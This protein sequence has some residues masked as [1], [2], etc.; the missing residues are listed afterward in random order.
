MTMPTPLPSPSTAR[1][2]SRAVATAVDALESRTL[3]SVAPAAVDAATATRLIDNGFAA[4]SWQHRQ[5]FAAPNEWVVELDRGATFK[6]ANKLVKGGRA[7]LEVVEKLTA[8]GDRVLV[9]V[10][11]GAKAR[12]AYAALA[13]VDGVGRVEPN[14][15]VYAEAVAPN[16]T[17][18][19]PHQWGLNN[20]GQDGGKADADIDA[21]E[22]WDVTTGSSSVVVAVVDSG[23]QYT[24]PDLAANMWRNPGEVAGDNVDND[25]N[26]YRDDVHGWNFVSN[27]GNPMDDNGHGTH[28]AGIIA[29]AGNNAAGVTGTSWNS[30]VMALKFL[31]SAGTG[32][33]A[34]AIKALDYARLM[35][36]TYGVN[37]RVINNSWGGGGFSQT[38]QNAIA[39]TETGGMLFVAAAGNGGS[40]GVGD[41]NDAV[42]VYPPSSTSAN[43]VA[44]AATDRNDALGTFSNYGATSVDLAAP[45]VDV[46]STYTGS[47]YSYLS[48]TSMATPYVS[49]VAALAFGLRPASTYQQVKDALLNGV[50]KV[51]GLTGKVL[52]GGRLNARK[53][54]DLIAA[55]DAPAAPSGLAAAAQGD[56]TIKLTWTDGSNNEQGFRV[57]RSA[58]GGGFAE[59]GTVGAN[60]A[61]YF[62]TAA[63]A[64]VAYAYRVRA[65]NGTNNSAFSN[66]AS[67]TVPVPVVATTAASV[68][69]VDSATAG[70][71]KG[72]YG[73]EGYTVVGDATSAPAYGSV[74]AAGKF[75]WTWAGSTADPRALQKAGSATDRVAATWYHS[76]PFAVDINL[77][78]TVTHRVALYMLDY[79]RNGRSQRVDVLDPSSGQVLATQAVSDFGDGKYVVLD[80]RGSVRVRVTRTAG[81]NAVIGGVF[82]GEGTGAPAL[83]GSATYLGADS[84]TGGSWK[85]AYGAQGYDLAGDAASLPAWAVV[86]RQ[87]QAEWTWAGSTA[88]A[89]ALQKAASSTDRQ[90]STWYTYGQ[91]TTDVNLTDGLRHKVSLYVVD[92]EAGGRAQR[93]EVLDAETGTVLDTRDVSAFAGGR[94]LSWEVGGP[95]RFRVTLTGGGNAVVSGVFVDAATTAA[96]SSTPPTTVTAAAA[97]PFASVKK[98]EEAAVWD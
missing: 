2:V 78:D 94:Y 74:A 49:G 97:S 91:M 19:S 92:W 89:R 50:D 60:V 20:T 6:A 34:N 55:L 76:E 38:L 39:R 17:Y 45:G 12:A 41:N 77:T 28:V 80:V 79:D 98:I 31:G 81:A 5:A 4:V 23:V 52:T 83:A 48:G 32:S 62:D 93:I 11:E 24:H 42:P 56:G 63:T 85:G 64:G 53:T 96:A 90:A 26:G 65:Y 43:V 35:K 10:P 86:N 37:V 21:P 29:A 61:T 33:T 59:V 15:A 87:G 18:Y 82:F 46:A 44:V 58:N 16:D 22:A 57:E 67:A 68:V 66:T 69:R 72:Q 70:A 8:A 9:R 84:T 27:T 7:D 25:G 71:W 51:A 13:G 47:G 54:L 95:V 36:G 14:F 75:D 88:D 30:K 3:M 73:T 1:R 40:D